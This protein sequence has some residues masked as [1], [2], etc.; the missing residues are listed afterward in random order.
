MQTADRDCTKAKENVPRYQLLC[1][2][3]NHTGYKW[4]GCRVSLMYCKCDKTRNSR[5]RSSQYS[6]AH[7][8]EVKWGEV[9]GSWEMLGIGVPSVAADNADPVKYLCGQPVEPHPPPPTK[10]II[11]KW[12][13]F[14]GVARA[15]DATTECV[16]WDMHA[17]TTVYKILLS[18]GGPHTLVAQ[19]K[20]LWY[21]ILIQA[22]IGENM[23][24]KGQHT[25]FVPEPHK[26]APQLFLV[27]D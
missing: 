27:I 18:P 22:Q 5:V 7:F 19:F 15:V 25:D 10:C 23:P 16:V 4:A 6:I 2:A 14:S 17:S 24:N 8:Q 3:A 11:H 12:M 21:E 20:L 1:L 9:A 26:K 13:W